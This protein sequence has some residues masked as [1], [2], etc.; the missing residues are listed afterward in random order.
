[1]SLPTR[2]TLDPNTI[3]NDIAILQGVIGSPVPST[4]PNGVKNFGSN[5]LTMSPTTAGLHIGPETSLAPSTNFN[6]FHVSPRLQPVIAPPVQQ[7]TQ[8]FTLGSPLSNHSNPEQFMSTNLANMH[9]SPTNTANV[10]T[11][12]LSSMS[13]PNLQGELHRVFSA[14]SYAYERRPSHQPHIVPPTLPTR[15]PKEAIP[16]S[17]STS[18]IEEESDVDEND[19]NSEMIKQFINMGFSKVQAIDALEKH[20]YDPH[21]ATNYLLDLQ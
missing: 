9:I 17:S 6:R 18:H 20:N 4:S 14:T 11:L 2:N 15:P 8:A 5:G 13:A 19:L 3:Q 10:Y 12:P 16:S 7:Q 21:K 1:E